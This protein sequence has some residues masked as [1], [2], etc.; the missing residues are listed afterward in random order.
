MHLQ[1][2]GLSRMEQKLV[3]YYNISNTK[4]CTPPRCNTK[5]AVNHQTVNDIETASITSGTV[6]CFEASLLII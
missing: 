4:Q 3:L 6:L 1:C 2:I 5:H